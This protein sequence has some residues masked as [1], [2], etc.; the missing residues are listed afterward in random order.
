MGGAG[1]RIACRRELDCLR[2]TARRRGGSRR[3][4]ADRRS[5]TTEPA[6]RKHRGRRHGFR[7]RSVAGNGVLLIA[8][9]SLGGL[10]D[11]ATGPKWQLLGGVM[12]A[13]SSSSRSPSRARGSSRCDD[14]VPH[15]RAVRPR[16]RDR[17]L[18]LVRGRAGRALLATS[19]WHR[20][21]RRR[22]GAHA[23]VSGN[24]ASDGLEPA[25]VWQRFGELT[26][27]ARPSKQ[28]DEARGHVLAWAE[29]GTW[30]RMS[31]RP[32]TPSFA[33]A[34][35][36]R[37]DAP[38]VVLQA[39]LDMVCERDA[40][41]PYDPREGRIHVVLDGDW[42]VAEGT[43]LGRTT[44][45]GSPLPS[46]SRTI[47]PSSTARSSSS[48]RSPRKRAFGAKALDAS[49]VAGRR[50]VNLDGT[51]D[52]VITVGCAG[53]ART[54]IRLELAGSLHQ[55]ARCASDRAGRSAGRSFG[56]EHRRR[57]GQRDKGARTDSGGRIPDGALPARPSRRRCEPQRDPREA[58]A[59]I[60][61][62]SESSRPSVEQPCESER[63][64]RPARGRGR[65]LA[66]SRPASRRTQPLS[67]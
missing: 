10:G 15:R 57:S 9:R 55:S 8:T 35:A 44:A 17:P 14:G 25:L 28:E 43:T 65:S 56:R 52:E 64:P 59:A 42:V 16:D 7:D 48:S 4:C 6:H 54:F 39:H 18:R 3:C 66:R 50:L 37:E 63:A 40:Q 1:E 26:R 21:A 38:I 46:G 31:M 27:I 47:P 67:W 23:P 49:L 60:V 41:S 30:T 29:L 62:N 51:S 19:P 24:G 53:S 45:S 11:A 5:G 22:C 20:P 34:V 32:A 36:G 58:R 12:S 33:S 13:S 61:A 2:R